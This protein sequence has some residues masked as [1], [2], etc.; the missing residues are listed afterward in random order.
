MTWE[1]QPWLAEAAARERDLRKKHFPA[2][3]ESGRAT[4]EEAD[5][6]IAAWRAIA[7]L[8]E[9][10]WTE[11]IPP[12]GFPGRGTAEGGGG[13]TFS[14]ST[15]HLFTSRALQALVADVERAEAARPEPVERSGDEPKLIRLRER[16][17]TIE[18]IHR[19]IDRMKFLIDDANAILR[20]RAARASAAA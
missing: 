6:E 19:P 13:A 14:W 3:I 18:A 17:A 15:L 2:L 1:P 11:R 9:R 16:L 4:K 7:D 12:R 10:G 5:A 20:A 8:M